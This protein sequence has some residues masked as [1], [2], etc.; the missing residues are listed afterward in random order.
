MRVHALH[1]PIRTAANAPLRLER[2]VA[3]VQ[4]IGG[5]GWG[6]EWLRV[7]GRQRLDVCPVWDARAMAEAGATVVQAVH[8]DGVRKHGE[9]EVT[10]GQRR[11]GGHV[12]GETG[13][14]GYRMRPSWSLY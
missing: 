4:A 14:F 7:G 5:S 8:V 13:S 9:A 11:L 6:S 2:A 3:R 10:V 12:C 1:N